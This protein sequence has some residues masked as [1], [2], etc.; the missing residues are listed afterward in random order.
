MVQHEL[1]IMAIGERFPALMHGRDFWVGH[2][3]DVD[4]GEQCGDAFIAQWK[5]GEPPDVAELLKRAEELRPVYDE[6]Q[7]RQRRN[8][9]LMST[10]W[11]QALDLPADIRERWAAY[12]QVLRDLPEQP[13]WPSDVQWPAEPIDD[14]TA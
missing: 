1:L 10:D 14:S 8:A 3:L 13:G 4:T 12:R 11:T 6:R 5:D 7:A 9:L 2:P